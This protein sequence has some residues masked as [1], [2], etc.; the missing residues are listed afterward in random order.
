MSEFVRSHPFY[1]YHKIG[2]LD[3]LFVYLFVIGTMVQCLFH[4]KSALGHITQW[5]FSSACHH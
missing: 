3:I 4:I 1:N 2:I 5:T